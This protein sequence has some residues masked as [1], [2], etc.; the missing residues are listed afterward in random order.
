[1][2][3]LFVTLFFA[4][5]GS[6][7]IRETEYFTH[8]FPLVMLLIL[9]GNLYYLAYYLW[10]VPPPGYIP[11]ADVAAYLKEREAENQQHNGAANHN[12]NGEKQLFMARTKEG[13]VAV[14]QEDI[15]AIFRQ[16]EYVLLRTFDRKVI[17]LEQ[18]LAEA[19][20]ELNVYHFFKIN[21]RYIVN[22]R[23]CTKYKHIEYGK[24]EL[25][26]AAPM[27]ITVEVSRS[28]AKEFIEWFKR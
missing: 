14:P 10:V 3:I 19:I 27:N 18:S 9:M 12:G 13:I 23:I 16:E 7:D 6:V 28:R 8:D 11:A 15:A 26:L 2:A 22:F 21:P 1:M 24:L 4:I 5:V 17:T 25:E 20:K